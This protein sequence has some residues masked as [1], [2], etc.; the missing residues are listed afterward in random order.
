[1]F[2]SRAEYRLLLRQDN[3]DLRLR[4]YGYDLGLISK[5]QYVKLENK[6][7]KIDEGLKK[8]KKCFK[9]IDG[10]GVALAQLLS[11]PEQSYTDLLQKYPEDLSDYGKE[12]NDQIHLEIKYEGYIKRQKNDA[13]KLLTTE[14]ILIP[15]SLDYIKIEGL[16]REAKEKLS[17]FKPENVAQAS[18]ISG[19]SPS[20]IQV[21]MVA[22]KRF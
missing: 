12:I 9:P 13:T 18:R 1:M 2:T 7:T 20:D 21:L 10:Q 16:S 3:A 4:H 15:S 8:L 6:K 5:E 22:L 17:R 11:R 19:I 14:N